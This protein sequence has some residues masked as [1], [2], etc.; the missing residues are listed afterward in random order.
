M[1]QPTPRVH[2]QIA[3]LA[4]LI[5][6]WTGQGSG[7]YPTIDSFGYTEE[8]T[9]GHVGKP[10]LTYSQRTRATDDGRLLHAETGYLRLV[11]PN[12]VEWI[13]AHPTGITEIQEGE[14]DTGRD[15]LRLEM[16]ST[17]IGRSGSAKDVSAVERSIELDGDTLSYTLRMAAV[18]QPLQH[19]LSAVLHRA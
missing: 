1:A 2:P 4:P 6:T 5:G 17:S 14:L 15:R 7:E 9:F 18:G 3:A 19:H 16:H 8:V 13:L 10:F 11:P 12:R